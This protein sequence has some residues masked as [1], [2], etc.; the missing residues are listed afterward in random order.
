MIDIFHFHV[1][2]KPAFIILPLIV[3]LL[4]VMSD[5][6]PGLLYASLGQGG[7]GGLYNANSVG[8]GGASGTIP[9]SG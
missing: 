9:V 8:G 2:F 1:R 5:G 7:A 3:G 6:K 4:V